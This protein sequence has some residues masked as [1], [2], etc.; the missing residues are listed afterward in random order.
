MSMLWH[1]L[2]KVW[3]VKQMLVYQV[4]KHSQSWS[5]ALVFLLAVH[6]VATWRESLSGLVSSKQ[7]GLGAFKS[8]LQAACAPMPDNAADSL[9]VLFRSRGLGL[10]LLAYAAQVGLFF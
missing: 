2:T 6:Q 8:K 3:L 4:H 9:D 7:Q 1:S 10:Q 5:Y